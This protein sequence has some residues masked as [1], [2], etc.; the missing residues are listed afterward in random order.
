MVSFGCAPYNMTL[1][2]TCISNSEKGT[3]DGQQGHVL[4]HNPDMMA[5]LLL[6]AC[7][8]VVG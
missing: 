6:G 1:R 5:C 7:G 8:H 3:L 2:N 4:G